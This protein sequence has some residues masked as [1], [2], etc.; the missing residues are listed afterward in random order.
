MIFQRFYQHFLMLLDNFNEFVY[1]WQNK[2]T[3]LRL[4]MFF[5]ELVNVKKINIHIYLCEMCLSSLL[6]SKCFHCYKILTF[7]K[8]IHTE[9]LNVGNKTFMACKSERGSCNTNEQRIQ[10]SRVNK[11]SFCYELL[12]LPRKFSSSYNRVFENLLASIT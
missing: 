1:C 9:G 8:K 5:S 2:N 7:N 10:F 3:K 11:T 12:I 4:D 6:V